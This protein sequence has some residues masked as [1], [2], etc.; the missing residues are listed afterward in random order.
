M[1]LLTNWMDLT[2][3]AFVVGAVVTII[4][5]ILLS[6]GKKKMSADSLIPER[7]IDSVKKDADLARRK[8]K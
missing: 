2:T 1:L 7:T 8:M 4:G 3:A 5:A 6:S